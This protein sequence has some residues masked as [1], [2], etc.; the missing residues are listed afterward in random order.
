MKKY[1]SEK[2]VTPEG[3]HHV[4]IQLLPINPAFDPF[5][6]ETEEAREMVIVGLLERVLSPLIEYRIVSK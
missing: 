5:E 6:I 1:R 4:R 2:A 3:W